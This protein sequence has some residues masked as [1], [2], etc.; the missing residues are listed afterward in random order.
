MTLIKNFINI[1]TGEKVFI[2]HY[3][4]K[5]R[6][7]GS[8]IYLNKNGK[9]L[10][11]FKPIVKQFSGAPSIGLGFIE[12]ALKTQEKLK[13]ISNKDSKENKKEALRN[14]LRQTQA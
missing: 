9:E 8:K 6:R 10:V 1:E 3:K 7:D 14:E 2:P 4:T 5:F 13:E 12:R 11:G